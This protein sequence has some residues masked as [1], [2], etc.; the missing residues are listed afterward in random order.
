MSR[1]VPYGQELARL[2]RYVMVGIA[3]NCFALGVYYALT[4]GLAIEPKTALTLSAMAGFGPA[5]AANR[6]W[7]FRATTRH[8]VSLWRYAA[9][10]LAS[11]VFQAAFLWLGVDALGLP[12]QYVVLVGLGLATVFFF[13]LQRIWIFHLPASARSGSKA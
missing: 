6:S 8:A 2:A 7:T 11:F 3:T 12:H 10:Y 4:F 13:L 1:G 5:Y 9:G